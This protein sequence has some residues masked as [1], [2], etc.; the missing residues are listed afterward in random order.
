MMTSVL[1]SGAG[2]DFVV[3][4]A[5]REAARP[6]CCRWSHADDALLS[7]CREPSSIAAICSRYGTDGLMLLCDSVRYDF[8]MEFY[9]PDGSTGMMCGNGGRCIAAFASYLGI[10]PAGGDEYVFEAP[11]ALHVA[12]ILSRSGDEW[13]VSLSMRDVSEVRE[14][15][16]GLFLDTGARHCVVFVPDVAEVD[17]AAVGCRLRRDA[18]FAPEGTNVDFVSVMPDGALAVRTFEKGVEG[19]TLACGTGVVA[20]VLAGSWRSGAP[21]GIFETRVRT[22]NAWMSVGFRREGGC[23]SG[24]T[25]TGPAA[26]LGEAPLEGDIFV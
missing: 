2:N 16:A 3:I 17:V 22:R 23:F 25:L 21:D 7:L 5:R 18:L 10:V 8:R 9:N 4:D 6:L 13:S 24:I 1:F 20:S 11:D 15:P 19:E 26:L 14:T 12:R